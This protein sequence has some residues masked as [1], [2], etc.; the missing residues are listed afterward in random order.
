MVNGY[1]GTICK[2]ICVLEMETKR[3][4]CDNERGKSERK[5]Q[6]KRKRDEEQGEKEWYVNS[7][8]HIN[9]C[10]TGSVLWTSVCECF[11]G[12]CKYNELVV[13]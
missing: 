3:K 8:V 1:G 13:N 12:H 4:I 2:C 5:R 7:K 9:T 6:R 10:F 11:C